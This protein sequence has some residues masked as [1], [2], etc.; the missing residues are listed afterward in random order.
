[1]SRF[2]W[3]CLL[4]LIPAIY[5]T[6]I[7]KETVSVQGTIIGMNQDQVQAG[8]TGSRD[9][10]RVA[11]KYNDRP[12]DTIEVPFHYY[13]EAKVG[14]T[15]THS[16]STFNSNYE[17]LFVIGVSLFFSLSLVLGVIPLLWAVFMFIKRHTSKIEI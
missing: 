12:S 10:F 3:I 15:F 11:V 17:G 1:M 8:K 2:N 5:M 4:L 13:L 6:I 16:V 9:R 7:A 14:D